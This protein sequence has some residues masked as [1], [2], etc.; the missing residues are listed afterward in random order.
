[1]AKKKE[2]IYNSWNEVDNGMKKMG[3]LQI[4]K[5]KLECELNLKINKLKED[6]SALCTN[7]SAEIKSIEKEISRFCEEHKDVFLNKRSKKLNFGTIAYRVS[8]KVKV[9]CVSAAI[10]TLK[11][12][13][14]DF[15]LRIK[16]EIDKDEVKKLDA[17]ILTK[18]GIN[19]IKEDKLSI[20]PA[21]IEIAAASKE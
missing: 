21:I 10:K 19:I 6:C 3:E 9:S 5:T 15:C 18:A 8:E 4:E 17:N 1:M 11:A 16:E 14:F 20:E 2:S 7:I 12:L 13:N